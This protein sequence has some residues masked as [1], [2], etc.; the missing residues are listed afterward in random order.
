LYC[1]ARSEPSWQ[2]LS[3]LL[4]C[5]YGLYLLNKDTPLR[6]NPFL[7]HWVEA[8]Q[9]LVPASSNREQPLS[10]SSTSNGQIMNQGI[11]AARLELIKSLLLNPEPDVFITASPKDLHKMFVQ[12]KQTIELDIAPYMQMLVEEG[13]YEQTSTQQEEDHTAQ[14]HGSEKAKGKGTDPLKPT[15]KQQWKEELL[16]RLETDPDAAIAELTHLPI[17]LQYLDL[18]TTL[19]Q[20]RTLQK[21]SIDPFPLIQNYLQHALRVAE[22]MGERPSGTPDAY[23]S[24]SGGP[25][26]EADGFHHG[27]AAQSRA[28]SLLLLFIRNL[29]R[30]ALIQP[31]DFY[32]EIQEICVRYVWIK[33]VREFRAFIE[34]K[35][36]DGENG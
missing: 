1:A 17:D 26:E 6:H 10:G 29:I 34:G 21:L 24:A 35:D 3:I 15:N 5:E 36:G 27:R 8:Y 31:E 33:E 23:D 18:L 30:K 20:D 9:R 2:R 28:V 22:Q 7:S 25:S 16:S 13:I 14:V 32:Y 19:L 11:N 4:N 12:N